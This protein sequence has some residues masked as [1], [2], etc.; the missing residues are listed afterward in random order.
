M[1]TRKRPTSTGTPKYL[2]YVPARPGSSVF[3]TQ[4]SKIGKGN[5]SIAVQTSG[6]DGNCQASGT[7]AP[8]DGGGIEGA[9][10]RDGTA[11]ATV[12]PGLGDYTTI[13]GS[14]GSGNCDTTDFWGTY[15]QDISDVGNHGESDPLTAYLTITRGDRNAGQ[16]IFPVT[17]HTLKNPLLTVAADCSSQ[18][19]SGYTTT[20]KQS[21]EWH[22]TVTL[23]KQKLSSRR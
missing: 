20:C 2:M 13:G 16:L 6:G 4:V 5:W 22:A 14:S 10:G 19:P 12:I 18:T 1:L 17:N 3:G 15:I 11:R 7:L 9:V 21:F 23:T 8:N